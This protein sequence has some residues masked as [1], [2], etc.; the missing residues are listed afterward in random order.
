MFAV[1]LS[2]GIQFMLTN[3]AKRDGIDFL[4]QSGPTSELIR[5]VDWAKTAIGDQQT[6]PQSLRSALSICINSNFPI[7][8]YW[9]RDLVLMYN[10]AWSPIPGSKHPWAFGKLAIEVWPEIWSDIE[11][12]FQKAFTGV[13]GGS[14]DALLPMQ[15]H[16][17]TEECY[18]DFTFTPIYG[19]SG[20]V[21]GVFNAVIETTYPVIN[22]RRAT[23]L[24]RLSEAVSGVSA[25]SDVYTRAA[26]VLSQARADVSFFYI[27]E[28]ASGLPRLVTSAPSGVEPLTQWPFHELLLNGNVKAIDDLSAYF[29]SVPAGHWPEPPTEALIVPMKG[30]DGNISGFMV[31]GASS[32]RRIDKDYRAFF[33]SL[34]N[35]ISAE[36]NTLQSLAKE[37][38]RA[39]S[40]AQIDKAK[41]AFFSNISHEFRTPLTL[42]L[43]PLEEV[44]HTSN[45]LSSIEKQNL[46]TSFRNSLRL[47]K[48]V[49]TLLDFSRI[50]AGKMEA[51][52]ERIAI[53][54]ATRDLASSFRSAIESAGLLYNVLI[55]ETKGPVSVDAEMWEKI[56]L[57][58][59]SNAF[60]YTERGAINVALYQCDDSLVFEVS[61]TG[62]GI[63]GDDLQKI[64]E[65]FYR[66]NNPGGRSQEGT[67]IGLALV[68]ELVLLHHGEINVKSSLGEGSTFTV[69]IPLDLDNHLGSVKRNDQASG[70]DKTRKAFIEEANKWSLISDGRAKESP[71]SDLTSDKPSI[72][73]AD[74]NSDMRDYIIRLLDDDFRVYAANNG[75][76]AFAISQKIVP[77]LVISDIMMPKL[78]GFGLLKKLRSNLATKGIPVIFLSARAG[79]DAR[80]EGIQAGADDYLVKPFSAKEL[81]ARVTNQVAINRTRRNTEKEF[82]NLFVQSPAHINIFR[83][84]DH[85][86]EFFHP[87]G[88]KIIGREITGQKIREALPELEGQGYF[89]LLDEVF[90]TGKTV[91]I[92]ERKAI[93]P[94]EQGNP[95][96]RY[97]QVTYLPWRGLDGNIQGVLQFSL[98]LTEQ[99]GANLKIK[100]SEE[101]FRLLSNSIPQFVW[102]ADASGNVEYM[103][104]QWEKYSG[105]TPEEGRKRFSS[106]IH[107]DDID[108]VRA[109]WKKS[110]QSK[111]P[112]TSEFRLINVKTG[113]HRWFFGHTVPLLDENG[114][115][116]K[117]IGSSSDIHAQKTQNFELENIVA[118][119][120]SELI[121]LNNML[122]V[123]NDE[124]S[125]A[126]TFLQTVLDSSVELV[127]AFD[128]DLNF[129]FV[130]KRLNAVSDKTPEDLV[131]KNLLDIR[132]GFEKTEEY[133]HLLRALNGETVHLD[134]R[135][136][137][138]D[139]SLV[140]ETFIIPLKQKGEIS[141]VVSMQRDITAT[142]RLTEQLRESNEQLKRS[143]EDLQQFA[144]VTSHD[145]KEPV[146]K[147]KMYGD[148]LNTEFAQYVPEKGRDY[149]L[150]IDRAT[151]RILAMIDGVLQYA[152]LE[153]SDQSAEEID[154]NV[155]IG[156]IVEDLEIPMQENNA[157][158][159][160]HRLPVINGYPTL[161][162]QLF[163]NLINNSL[164]FRKNDVPPK[165]ELTFSETPGSGQEI[166]GDYFRIIVRDNGVGFQNDYAEKIFESF[167]RLYSK[168][169]YEGTGLGLALCRKIVH[170]HDGLIKA[171]GELNKGA[172]FTIL[173]PKTILKNRRR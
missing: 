50:E 62:I 64:F 34:A 12:Q 125:R 103:S 15:R 110:M 158:V 115:V 63:R 112:W 116:Q 92:H 118:E 104:D 94:D 31:A 168:D 30:A 61:D 172:T 154:L 148:I 3:N 54:K 96:D 127:T 6:W 52:F 67:G 48:L 111:Q 1:D 20:K 107:Q 58:L 156:N 46:E 29:A 2:L 40:L 87:L 105:T 5:S 51:K 83:G 130:N 160:Y 89:E 152:T 69:T 57:N 49:N 78:D 88:K 138:G 119:R 147:I 124:L 19:E 102:I 75:E 68:K 100:E 10:E 74:D 77:D 153:T 16:G 162:Y 25:T 173:F 27:Y 145:L 120:T 8:I 150:R 149:L 128:R 95:V 71:V 53:A 39:E 139:N 45:N 170:R 134:A 137:H 106:F 171:S 146:R 143:N 98:D 11:P 97:F 36:L 161:I 43:S 41:T 17:Y 123:K 165:I 133:G 22:E 33:E 109:K 65:R 18:F 122:K 13:P 136:P 47:Q 164:K 73:V 79:E 76:D 66:V 129:T 59:I 14:K 135:R 55:E 117:W 108:E 169:K 9:G 141:G 113:E 80:V 142:I 132:Q 84:P 26:T 144:H 21:E 163:Y 167:T 99:V 159:E 121:K 155:V 82:F 151:S 91:S 32:R 114:N 44:L 126:Q 56:V 131:G 23:V 37:R 166:G 81:L 28:I 140:F 157:A 7:A 35:I 24:Q 72:V 85:L 4:N 90:T 101:R 86:V 38:E 70:D 42:M 93:F 60:K